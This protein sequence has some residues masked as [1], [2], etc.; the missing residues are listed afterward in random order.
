ML[1]KLH[2]LMQIARCVVTLPFM[3]GRVVDADMALRRLEEIWP[4]TGKSCYLENAPS[5]ERTVLLSVIIPSYNNER[6]ILPCVES[7]LNQKTDISYEVIVIN[8]GSTDGSKELL[9]SRYGSN[10]RVRLVHQENK[11][12]SGARNTGIDMALGEYLLFVD[13][14]DR[15][16]PGAVET[17]MA[18]ALRHDA[19]MVCGGYT[20][21]FPNGKTTVGQVF[22]D[23]K[24]QPMGTLPGYA[25]G[26][27]YKASLFEHLRFPGGYWFE[28]SISAQIIWPLCEDS[29]YTVRES[30]YEYLM[31]PRGISAQ[32]VCKPK[33][34]DSLW[35]YRRLLEER[36]LFDLSITQ[37]DYEHFLEMVRLT[38]SRTRGLDEDVKR[39][40]FSLQIQLKREYF[41]SFISEGGY[42]NRNV[43]KALTEHRYKWYVLMGELPL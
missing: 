17:L 2:R 23:G 12:L 14:D 42:V 28:D 3:D 35:L 8:D 11:G 29:C 37:A 33:S 10:P 27:V 31:N 4:D 21:L 20:C 18:S 16:L 40:V 22:A 32:A 43:E 9:D 38:Y 15:L 36:K 34:L 30:V 24:V 41:A 19:L 7:V 13:S 6:Y 26:K 25:W 39:S 1:T 5:Q